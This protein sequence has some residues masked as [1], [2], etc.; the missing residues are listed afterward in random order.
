MYA[1][2]SVYLQQTIVCLLTLLECTLSYDVL[3]CKL[4][5]ILVMFCTHTDDND[6]C[7]GDDGD[8]DG[9]GDDNQESVT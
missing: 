9:G 8:D 5:L 6:H 3:F 1:V 4:P 2:M 7:D